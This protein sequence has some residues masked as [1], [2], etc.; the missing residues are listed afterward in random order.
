M[1]HVIF[2]KQYLTDDQIPPP[3]A[4]S[5]SRPPQTRPPINF[6]PQRDSPNQGK[7]SPNNAPNRQKMSA[8]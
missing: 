6:Q 7:P 3:P 1:G 2:G 5:L 4:Q 8:K